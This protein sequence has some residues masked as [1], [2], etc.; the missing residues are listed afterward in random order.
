M[1]DLPKLENWHATRECLHQ[2]AL[3]MSAIKV[4]CLPP[5]PN[6]LQYSLSL[7]LRGLSTGPLDMGGELRFD[8]PRLRLSYARDDGAAFQLD[9]AGRDQKS[10]YEDV[11]SAFASVGLD[12]APA[13]THIRHSQPFAIPRDQAA[14]YMTILDAAYTALARFRARLTGC[15]SPLALW[16]HHF[17]LAF[18][19]FDGANMDEHKQAHLAFG[20]APSS[21]G[22]ER[23]YFYAY[24]WSPDAGYARLP[25]APPARTESEG[26]IGLYLGYDDLDRGDGFHSQV[27][28]VLLDYY[29]RATSQI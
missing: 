10:L 1:A 14:A 29:A 11:L 22:L 16:A 13:R 20:F 23:P 19:R 27:E 25:A 3:V 7:R 24:A 21:P 6:S 9:V 26:Y 2:V 18:M 8:M 15:M 4:A 5:Q 28:H 12:I 17:D